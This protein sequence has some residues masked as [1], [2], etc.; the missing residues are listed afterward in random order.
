[1]ISESRRFLT[2][3]RQCNHRFKMTEISCIVDSPL[4]FLM[5]LKSC[6]FTNLRMKIEKWQTTLLIHH[7]IKCLRSVTFKGM[8]PN[9]S[10]FLRGR[11]QVFNPS[12]LTVVF[13]ASVQCDSIRT[14]EWHSSFFEETSPMKQYVWM[15]MNSLSIYQAFDQKLISCFNSFSK[16]HK[17]W[18]IKGMEVKGIKI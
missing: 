4:L 15:P 12:N 7:F 1:M 18:Y 11:H 8:H 10:F 17:R 3:F 6:C 2:S 5:N 14:A 16:V 9:G 13:F